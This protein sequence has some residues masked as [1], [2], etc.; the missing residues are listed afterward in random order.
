MIV[1]WLDSNCLNGFLAGSLTREIIHSRARSAL[2]LRL[3]LYADS[4]ARY[5]YNANSTHRMVD[6]SRT[7]T[8]LDDFKTSPFSKNDIFSWDTNVVESDMTV[9]M[10][11]IIKPKH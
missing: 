4:S 1:P 5:T 11:S 9:A 10:R 8:T 7:K 6:S 2:V 3:V